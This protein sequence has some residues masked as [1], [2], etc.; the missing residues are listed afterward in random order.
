MVGSLINQRCESLTEPI[1]P[2]L[3]KTLILQGCE[4]SRGP[5]EAA[6]FTA[7]TFT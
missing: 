5:L 3:S 7:A 6:K 2:S 4:Q 1:L